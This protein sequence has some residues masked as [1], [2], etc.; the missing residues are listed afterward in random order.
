MTSP[1]LPRS[2]S[3]RSG[4]ATQEEGHCLQYLMEYRV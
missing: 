4:S 1:W 3:W 2:R